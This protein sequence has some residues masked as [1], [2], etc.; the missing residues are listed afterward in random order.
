MDD[1]C[2]PPLIVPHHPPEVGTQQLKVPDG[3]KS[4]SFECLIHP[5]AVVTG[6][7]PF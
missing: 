6:E 5:M 1:V 3:L 2:Y 7:G 4:V